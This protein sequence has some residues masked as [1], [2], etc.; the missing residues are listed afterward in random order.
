VPHRALTFSIA[1]A[2]D[3]P[4]GPVKSA[5]RFD[6]STSNVKLSATSTPEQ[7]HSKRISFSSTDSKYF[8]VLENSST[9]PV[10]TEAD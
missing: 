10:M 9:V 6:A 1:V 7:T 3:W 5:V 8:Q 2:F 4:G